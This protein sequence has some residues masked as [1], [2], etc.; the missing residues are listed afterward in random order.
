[1]DERRL[2]DERF[3]IR[4]DIGFWDH[5]KSVAAGADGRNLFL[6]ALGWSRG[7]LTDGAIPGTQLP[8][9]AFKT[10]LSIDAA[11]AAADKLVEVG[12]WDREPDGWTVHDFAE[13]QLTRED[14]DKVREA[15]S[16]FCG[17]CWRTVER[18]QRI[19]ETR[20]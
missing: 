11:A 15:W 9:L 19:A 8:L 17:I 4:V 5:P 3:Y 7:Q 12:M 18:A 13:H 14:I 10:G 16:Y 20:D 6:C 1:M 2:K